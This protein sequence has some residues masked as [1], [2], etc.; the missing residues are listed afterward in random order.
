L[1]INVLRWIWPTA[2]YALGFGRH[3]FFQAG[4]QHSL[5]GLAVYPFA[6]EYDFALPWLPGQPGCAVGYAE[7]IADGLHDYLHR[8]AFGGY[9]TLYAIDLMAIDIEQNK[10]LVVEEG[11]FASTEESGDDVYGDAFF[12]F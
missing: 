4:I 9:D 11:R 7:H 1:K 8:A 12:H 10:Q 5:D 6:D 2:Q 3:G